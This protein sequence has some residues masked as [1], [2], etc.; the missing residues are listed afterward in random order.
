M[1]TNPPDCTPPALNVVVPLASLTTAEPGACIPVPAKHPTARNAGPW[2]Q[3]A[4]FLDDQH[5]ASLGLR[6]VQ[7]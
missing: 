7:V 5:L 2:R 6:M 4:L 1:L 3:V